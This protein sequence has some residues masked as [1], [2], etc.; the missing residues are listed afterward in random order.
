MY[1]GFIKDLL[2]TFLFLICIIFIYYIQDLNKYKKYILFALLICLI[3]DLL[4][5]L[6]YKYHCM[7]YGYN[8]PTFIIIYAIIIFLFILLYGIVLH[9]P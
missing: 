8:I 3:I 6:N 9:K 5:S 7:N 4:F 2:A 1:I